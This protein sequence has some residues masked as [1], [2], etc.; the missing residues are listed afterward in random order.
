MSSFEYIIS[1]LFPQVNVNEVAYFLNSEKKLFNHDF[2]SYGY[3]NALKNKPSSLMLKYKY[4]LLYSSTINNTFALEKSKNILLQNF[5]NAQ[6][7]YFGF[8]KLAYL[9]KE[10]KAKIYDI[11]TDLCMTPLSN[12]KDNTIIN[13]YDKYSNTKYYYRISDIINIVCNALSN[14]PD[15]FVEP[16]TPKNPYTNINF[17]VCQ[18]YHIY[19]TIRSSSYIM[20]TLLHQYFLQ[21]FD[22]VKFANHNEC[23][24][25]DYAIHNYSKSATDDDKY[26]YIKDMILQHRKQLYSLDIHPTFPRKKLTKTFEVYL[27]DY[28]MYNYS[29]NPARRT[30]SIKKLKRDLIRFNRLNPTYGRKIFNNVKKKLSFSRNIRDSSGEFIFDH[31][32]TYRYE[33]SFVDNVFVESPKNETGDTMNY[34]TNQI[35]GPSNTERVYT[36]IPANIRSSLNNVIDRLRQNSIENNTSNENVV[37]ENN[38]N[39]DQ[40]ETNQDQPET[41]L[42]S[43]NDTCEDDENT[44]EPNYMSSWTHEPMINIANITVAIND[45]N[46]NII[47]NENSLSDDAISDINDSDVS[48]V[49]DVND[50]DDDNTNDNTPLL[51]NNNNVNNINN[52]NNDN[53]DNNNNDNNINNNN[54][55]NNNDNNNNDNNNNQINITI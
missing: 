18:L 2:I 14:C 25:R 37:E 47:N 27:K 44:E 4:K 1:K 40:P 52:D 28:L 31:V 5:F 30:A 46:E 54:N 9:Y 23:F 26:T 17:S 39:Q 45:Q 43:N 42:V 22:I 7:I 35:I 11:N 32:N 15:F 36:T 55:N 16:L 24:I 13:I 12:F 33:F 34:E 53:N 21:N 38:T 8:C 41:S 48:D 10:K 50:T 6:K 20:P 51:S 29:L 49:S 3:L 19:F